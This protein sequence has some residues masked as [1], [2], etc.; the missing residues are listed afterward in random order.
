MGYVYAGGVWEEREAFCDSL[1]LYHQYRTRTIVR[2]DARQVGHVGLR[3][4]TVHERS[5]QW[6]RS[7]RT[8]S[9]RECITTHTSRE[10]NETRHT[11]MNF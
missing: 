1:D 9:I 4:L 3:L 2:D 11:G 7:D 10:C 5:I 8:G 6:Y